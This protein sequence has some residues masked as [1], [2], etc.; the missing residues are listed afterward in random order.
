MIYK[1]KNW[2]LVDL[3]RIQNTIIKSATF[4]KD[5]FLSIKKSTISKE[6]VLSLFFESKFKN[7]S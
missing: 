5:L 7:F 4:K 2:Y 6:I 1:D 3:K